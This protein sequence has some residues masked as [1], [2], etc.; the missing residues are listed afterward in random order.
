MLEQLLSCKHTVSGAW[1]RQTFSV[2]MV[3]RMIPMAMCVWGATWL[4][5][6]VVHFWCV[7]FLEEV[8]HYSY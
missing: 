4:L 7:P 6:F 3:V 8:I 2:E 5:V 1:F